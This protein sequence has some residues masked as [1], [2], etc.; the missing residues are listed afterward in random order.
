MTNKYIHYIVFT[1][2][3]VSE[4][5]EEVAR[6]GAALVERNLMLA[7]EQSST[8]EALQAAET[9]TAALQVCCC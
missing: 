8:L 5:T 4:R 7:R 6:L 1:G 9:A 2:L 3:Q